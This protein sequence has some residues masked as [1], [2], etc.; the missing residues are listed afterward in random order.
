MQAFVINKCHIWLVD[1]LDLAAAG[2]HRGRVRTD[3]QVAPKC[4]TL[5]RQMFPGNIKSGLPGPEFSR[6]FL[7]ANYMNNIYE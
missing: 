6:P 7:Y 2:A 5:A 1:R 3:E 4:V